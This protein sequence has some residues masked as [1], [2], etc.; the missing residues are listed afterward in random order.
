[1]SSDATQVLG[2]IWISSFCGPIFEVNVTVLSREMG[3]YLQHGLWEASPSIFMAM[4]GQPLESLRFSAASTDLL[5]NCSTTTCLLV[6]VLQ[7]G[8]E[9]ALCLGNLR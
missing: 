7:G 3:I 6:F 4:D 1:M 5:F 2:G 9:E 8:N